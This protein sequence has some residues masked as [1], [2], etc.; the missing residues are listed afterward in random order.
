MVSGGFVGV[1]VFFVISGFLISGLLFDWM[2]EGRFPL[3][4]FYARRICR[5]FP[6]LL[7]VLGSC[8]LFGWA[9]LLPDEFIRFGQHARG[10]LLYVLNYVLSAESG[11]FDVRAETKPLLHLWSLAIEEQF[12][13]FWPLLL[14]GAYKAKIEIGK[15]VSFVFL[16]S[17]V[18]CVFYGDRFFHDGFY[19]PQARFW[20]FLA[21]AFLAREKKRLEGRFSFLPFIGL[22]VI[23]GAAFLLDAQDPYPEWRALFPVL[24]TV[25]VLAGGE[26][27]WFNETVLSNPKVVYIGL[28][29]YPLYLWHWP[30]FSFAR[31][32]FGEEALTVAVRFSLLAA[33][34]RLASLTFH[35]VDKPIRFGSLPRGTPALARFLISV[36][37]GMV[38]FGIE[39]R[40]LRSYA[41][42]FGPPQLELLESKWPYPPEKADKVD[43]GDISFYRIGGGGG[44]VLFLGDCNVQQ[45]LPRF[46]KRGKKEPVI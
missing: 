3:L 38:S 2:E 27:S 33:S 13:I 29:S 19:F 23:M 1:D 12:Y 10:A 45:Y 16:C 32:V 43:L 30:L 24:G 11:Y 35:F 22:A 44:G 42:L 4:H 41:G 46:L 5:L 6:A 40:F 7:L 15:L 17:L 18:L 39:E 37:L 31:M 26:K 14:F 9:A 28:I 34:F 25:L 8:L 36:F 21:G 20:E